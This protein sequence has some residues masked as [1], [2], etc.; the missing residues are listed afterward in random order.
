GG[1]VGIGTTTPQA[2]LD[3]NGSINLPNTTSATVG[4]LSLGGQP[5]L[6]NYGTRNTFVG[7]SGNFT[8]GGTDNVGTG[9]QSLV[10]NTTGSNN[11]GFGHFAL[12]SS[13]GQSNSAF[14]DNAL[15]SLTTGNSNIALGANAGD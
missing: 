14:G 6:H 13:N 11:N 15:G 5:F 2:T 3:V 12:S 9:E 10:S 1:S 7:G 8:M 4:V